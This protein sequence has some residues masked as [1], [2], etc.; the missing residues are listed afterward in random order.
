[1]TKKKLSRKKAAR[2]SL[3]KN[4]ATSLIF[5]EK[6]KTTLPKARA[7]APYLERIL[8]L[9]QKKDLASRREIIPLL[10]DRKAIKKIYEDILNR[11]GNRKSGFCQ[12]IKLP[13]KRKGDFAEMVQISLLLEPIKMEKTKENKGEQKNKKQGNKK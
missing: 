9:A 2:K 1:M 3:L 12:L 8:R 13:E 11:L 4:L 7:V 6:I 10:A 5:Y